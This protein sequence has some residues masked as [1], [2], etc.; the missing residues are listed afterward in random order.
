MAARVGS[1]EEKR[2]SRRKKKKNEEEEEKEKE[3]GTFMQRQ[4]D[5]RA[6]ITS[7]FTSQLEI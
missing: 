7:S 2:R 3:K 4:T 6:D 1:S 5:R